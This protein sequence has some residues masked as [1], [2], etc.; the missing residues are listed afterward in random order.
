MLGIFSIWVIAATIL[1]NSAQ[2]GLRDD[3]HSFNLSAI[4]HVI[5]QD[6]T[7]PSRLNLHPFTQQLFS[8]MGMP[9]QSR[10][11]HRSKFPLCSFGYAITRSAAQRLLNDLASPQ[12][13]EDGPRAYDVALLNAC[14]K[15]AT[16]ISSSPAW[17]PVWPHTTASLPYKQ[18][19]GGLR[20]WTLNSE[21]FHHM[22]G[23]SQIA[24]VGELMG[25]QAG[26]PPVDRAAQAQ[27]AYRNETTNIDCGF[28]GGAF[29][30]DDDDVDQ[31]HYLQEH[32]GHRGRCLK[33]RNK[34][35][36]HN[37]QIV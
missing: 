21:L 27:V 14:Q 8:L 2:N 5:Y 25:E 12:Y 29:A 28:W 3:G 30:F 31:L 19:N 20:C 7:L 18:P 33:D 22:P 13:S 15:G 1:V 23:R 9:E 17:E 10:V 26:I 36:D 11:L 16:T 24:E 35:T 32:V 37:V 6:P 34:A 4:H